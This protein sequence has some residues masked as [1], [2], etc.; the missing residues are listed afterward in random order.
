M[1]ELDPLERK[2]KPTECQTGMLK[3]VV[4]CVEVRR[5]EELVPTAGP[6]WGM[7]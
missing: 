3:R 2:I 5:V 6:R 4:K 7:C 1:W